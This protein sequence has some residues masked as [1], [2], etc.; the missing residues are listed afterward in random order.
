MS[1]ITKTLGAVTQDAQKDAALEQDLATK[2]TAAGNPW[3]DEMA[4]VEVSKIQQQRQFHDALRLI[5]MTYCT[6]PEE[7]TDMLNRHLA[8]RRLAQTER[9]ISVARGKGITT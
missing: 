5:S 6:T 3:A 4:K 7:L 8:E 1:E 2:M 9:D